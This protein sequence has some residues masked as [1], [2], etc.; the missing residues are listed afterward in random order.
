[1]SDLPL[2]AQEDKNYGLRTNLANL[3]TVDI[4]CMIYIIFSFSRVIYYMVAKL[5]VPP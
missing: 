1:M 4:A 3:T 2:R 5:D